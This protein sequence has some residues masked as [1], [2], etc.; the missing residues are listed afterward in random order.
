MNRILWNRFKWFLRTGNRRSYVVIR[1]GVVMP[2]QQRS[3]IWWHLYTFKPHRAKPKVKHVS[4][5]ITKLFKGESET[6]ADRKSTDTRWSKQKRPKTSL[7]EASRVS[8]MSKRAHPGRDCGQIY[9]WQQGF[10][11]LFIHIIHH[12]SR[13]DWIESVLPQQI[14][15]LSE[16]SPH[17]RIY[18]MA[19]TTTSDI[20]KVSG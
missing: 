1:S 12:I 13:L 2:L 3:C 11:H 14:A 6:V 8:W 15:L 7:L 20:R 9:P 5:S 17:H 4:S 10:K 16:S 19:Y 18:H